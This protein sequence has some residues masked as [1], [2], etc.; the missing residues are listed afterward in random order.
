MIWGTQ[1][2]AGVL[3]SSLGLN[4]A[5]EGSRQSLTSVA[6][7]EALNPAFEEFYI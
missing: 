5:S 7:R 2:R 4:T 6:W 3:S 1:E